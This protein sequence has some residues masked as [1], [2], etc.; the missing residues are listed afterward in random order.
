M[1]KKTQEKLENLQGAA[2]IMERLYETGIYP[3]C[4]QAEAHTKLL[5][6]SIKEHF[7]PDEMRREFKDIGI[8]AKYTRMPVYETDWVGLMEYLSDLGILIPLLQVDEQKLEELPNVHQ[9]IMEHFVNPIEH[10]IK[11]NPNKQGRVEKTPIDVVDLTPPQLAQM[12]LETK[13]KH[14]TAL[15]LVEQAKKNMMQCPLLKNTRNMKCNFGSVSLLDLVPTFNTEGIIQEF[16]VELLMK[17]GKISMSDLDE[18][19]QKGFISPN[20]IKRFRSTQD[21]QLRFVV[22]ELESEAKQ[23]KMFNRKLQRAAANRRIV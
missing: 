19:I 2:L 17:I 21:I 10:Y 11:L 7:Y 22:Q 16:G 20:E 1:A 8:V 13:R 9:T 15:E 4:K 23:F 12:W 18:Y 5:S 3:M 14:S 6:Q